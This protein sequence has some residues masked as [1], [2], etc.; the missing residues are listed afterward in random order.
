M[1]RFIDRIINKLYKHY[2]M[3][4]YSYYSL[5]GGNLKKKIRRV[6]SL[7]ESD[8]AVGVA[9]ESEQALPGF[10]PYRRSGYYRYMLGRYLYSIK[11]LRNKVVLDCAC[12][13]GWGSFL[14]SDY[15]RELLAIDLDKKAIDFSR[16]T[17]KGKK[18]NFVQHSALDLENLN[19]RFDVILGFELIEHL[20]SSDGEK[21]LQQAN[22]VLAENGLIILSSWFPNT[23][24]TTEGIRTDNKFH[25]HLYTKDEIRSLLVE[26]GY[27][28]PRFL[29][30]FMVIAA[31]AKNNKP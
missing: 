28:E 21:L 23:H 31:K 27:S 11:Y 1:H 15:A 5:F 20:Q 13:F 24:E 29:G 3:L 19:R 10:V 8:V 17:W 4:H 7:T 26:N 14:V 12:G 18:L 16:S 22:R 2:V 6:I 9:Q 25:L 30:S